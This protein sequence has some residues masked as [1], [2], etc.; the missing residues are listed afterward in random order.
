MVRIL[1]DIF[2]IFPFFLTPFSST[3]FLL[4]FTLVVFRG[5]KIVNGKRI[6]KC[7]CPGFLLGKGEQMG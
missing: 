1:S 2:P 3:V 7:V 4:V 6:W 5:G